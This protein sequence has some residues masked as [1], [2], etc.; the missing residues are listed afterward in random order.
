MKKINILLILILVIQVN[1]GRAVNVAGEIETYIASHIKEGKNYRK[2]LR[3]DLIYNKAFDTTE[4][5]G[6]I[7]AEEDSIK[8]SESDKIYIREAYINQDIYFEKIF[9]SMNFKIGKI[10]YTWGNADELKP[11]DIINPQDLSFLFFKPIQE[12]KYALLSGNVTLFLTENLFLELVAVPEFH[13]TKIM[14]SKIFIIKDIEEINK[15]PYHTL[16]NEILP[17]DNLHSGAYAS[18]LGVMLFDIDTHFIYYKGY[19]HLPVL[20]VSILNIITGSFSFTPAYKEI[21]MFGFDFQRALL[22]GIAIRGEIAYF[23]MGKF[24]ILNNEPD[25]VNNPLSSPLIQDLLSGGNGYLQ[26]KYVEYTSG[27]DSDDTIINNLYFNLQINGKYIVKHKNTLKVDNNINS[28]VG[29]IKYS[30]LRK[31]LITKLKGFY[32]INDKAYA[33]GLDVKY[34]IN[35]N[36]EI[37]CGGWLLDGKEDTYYGQFKDND[38]IYIKGVVKF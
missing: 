24:F 36:Y 4:I 11:V 16:N 13:S 35:S 2:N 38:F 28:F 15:N 20:E 8:V 32:N 31:K 37:S 6:I 27:F 23:T 17:S 3:F 22:S 9:D 25:D 5:K 7:R 19:D 18:R 29:T 30:L 1:I 14:N 10:I 26:K 34:N 12:R 33:G 21:E